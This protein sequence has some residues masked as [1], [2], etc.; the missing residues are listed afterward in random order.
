MSGQS[1]HAAEW[2]IEPS[3]AA[4]SNYNNNVWLSKKS[5]NQILDVRIEPGLKLNRESENSLL[6]LQTSWAQK[7]YIS[8]DDETRGL[9]GARLNL[10]KEWSK[11]L[12]QMDAAYIENSTTNSETT[13]GSKSLIETIRT[14]KKITPLWRTLLTSSFSLDFSLYYASVEFE[15]TEQQ[16]FDYRNISPSVTGL[17]QVTENIQ[18]SAAAGASRYELADFDYTVDSLFLQTG[19]KL[20]L[21]ENSQAGFVIGAQHIRSKLKQVL[22]TSGSETT[23]DNSAQFTLKADYDLAFEKGNIGLNASRNLTPTS[24]GDVQITDRGQILTKYYWSENLSSSL[25][26]TADKR[27]NISN[28]SNTVNGQKSMTT[29]VRTSWRKNENWHLS[30]AY[31]W[32]M[33]K[34]DQQNEWIDSHRVMLSTRY[35]WAKKVFSHK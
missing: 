20:A 6:S 34:Y 5:K 22:A 16:W 14:E 9:F 8:K 26:V 11:Q 25:T 7:K 10:K 32:L 1:V 23:I 31:R 18:W 2:S 19:L 24:Q 17:Y 35:V 3:I 4:R 30:L 29:R 13:D 12:F 21:N 28:A 33:R 15:K 27:D